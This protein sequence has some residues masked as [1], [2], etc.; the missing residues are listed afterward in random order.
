LGKQ[1]QGD[2]EERQAACQPQPGFHRARP[3]RLVVRVIG[4][5]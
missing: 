5:K 4:L 3:C 1:C 2:E